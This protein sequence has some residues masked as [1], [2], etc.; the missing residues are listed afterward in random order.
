MYIRYRRSDVRHRMSHRIRHRMFDLHIVRSCIQH[1]IRHRIRHRMRYS[2]IW[3]R[4]QHRPTT[5]L[6]TLGP[7]PLGSNRCIKTPVLPFL[8]WRSPSLCEGPSRERP[9]SRRLE[10]ARFEL[11]GGQGAREGGAVRAWCHTWGKE[12]VG[13]PDGWFRGGDVGVGHK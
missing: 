12:A 6:S 11:G 2:F 10:V 7:W 9:P 8:N 13:M 3:I 1:R 4:A 5:L